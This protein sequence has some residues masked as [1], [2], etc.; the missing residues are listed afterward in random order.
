MLYIIT[1]YMHI[2]ENYRILILF[3][4]PSENENLLVLTYIKI[5]TK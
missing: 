4:K 5:R 1:N 3:Q 2:K